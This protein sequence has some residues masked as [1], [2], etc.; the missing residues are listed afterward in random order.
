LL[1]PFATKEKENSSSA[2][3]CCGLA[4]LFLLHFAVYGM[5]TFPDR[6]EASGGI[7][8]EGILYVLSKMLKKI[9][10]PQHFLKKWL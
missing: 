10:S 9:T 2:F 5:K 8:A 7:L 6:D 4:S 1:F 3:L